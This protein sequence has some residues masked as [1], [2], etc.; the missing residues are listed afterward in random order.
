MT[1]ARPVDWPS[2]ILSAGDDPAALRA[3]LGDAIAQIDRLKRDLTNSMPIAGESPMRST[4]L[5]S[6]PDL[7]AGENLPY[8]EM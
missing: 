6:A 4:Y 5:T 7:R 8:G 2:R 3:L 1:D